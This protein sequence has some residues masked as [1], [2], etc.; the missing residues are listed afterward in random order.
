MPKKANLD[1]L[2]SVLKDYVK[3]LIKTESKNVALKESDEITDYSKHNL[4]GLASVIRRDWQNVYFGARPYLSAMSSLD[5][6]DD[7]YGMDSAD[8]IV[9]YFLANA[10]TWRG[11][12]AKAVKAELNKRLKLHR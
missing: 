9:R 7:D 6:L 11:P 1:E 4:A 2:R 5:S 3:Y 8:S 12:V 10:T